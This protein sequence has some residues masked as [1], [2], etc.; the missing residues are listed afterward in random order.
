MGQ[1][2]VKKSR[3]SIL[4]GS[5]GYVAQVVYINVGNDK[6]RFDI[7][8]V[9][10]DAQCAMD[11]WPEMVADELNMNADTLPDSYESLDEDGDKITVP[12]VRDDVSPIDIIR[13]NRLLGLWM[14]A[15]SHRKI[16]IDGENGEPIEVSIGTYFTMRLEELWNIALKSGL[17]GWDLPEECTPENSALLP[18]VV[19][20]KLYNIIENGSS[21]GAGAENFFL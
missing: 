14:K 7:K 1:S 11:E 10:A 20:R 9:D 15:N 6:Y 16:Q 18:K 2:T 12:I 19:K 4:R 21:L 8:E 13:D 5:E 17:A 3:R